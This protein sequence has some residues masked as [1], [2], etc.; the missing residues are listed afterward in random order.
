M[1]K[2]FEDFV[3]K[4]RTEFILLSATHGFVNARQFCGLGEKCAA[5]LFNSFAA[6]LQVFTA[7]V[8][9]ILDT[10]AACTVKSG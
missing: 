2:T 6:I 5:T 7:R 1:K 9:A 10:P 3:E 8:I 4:R